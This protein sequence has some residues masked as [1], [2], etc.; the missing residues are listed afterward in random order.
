MVRWSAVRGEALEVAGCH[1]TSRRWNY[2]ASRD[3]IGMTEAG[4]ML[5][6]DDS[7]MRTKKKAAS[8]TLAY[9]RE[10][11]DRYVPKS[12]RHRDSLDHPDRYTEL[13]RHSHELG[14]LLT[15]RPVGYD[16]GSGRRAFGTTSR[17]RRSLRIGWPRGELSRRRW[18]IDCERIGAMTKLGVVLVVLGACSGDGGSPGGPDAGHVGQSC[19][20]SSDSCTGDTV[21]ISNQCQSAFTRGYTISSL[22]IQVPTTKPDGTPWDVGGGA[23]DLYIVVSTDGTS[24]GMT[25]IVQDQFSAA[26]PDTFQ[27]TLAA[28]TTLDVHAFDSDVTSDDDAFLCEAMPVTAAELRT[29]AVGCQSQGYTLTFTIQP[30]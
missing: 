30:R 28:T 23:P 4:A 2:R 3:T 12:S 13:W 11:C 29:R 10:L 9:L 16:R 24:V 7:A 18:S 20:P 5:R 1:R 21:C 6:Q 15:S 8:L 19:S 14:H 27:V 25:G 22:A 17:N 26:Y